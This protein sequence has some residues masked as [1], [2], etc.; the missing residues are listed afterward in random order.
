MSEVVPRR[1]LPSRRKRTYAFERP[2]FSKL[3]GSARPVRIAG[4]RPAMRQSPK[5]IAKP[6]PICVQGMMSGVICPPRMF[7]YREIS[8]PQ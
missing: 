1:V 7:T 3:S 4:Q 6:V 5:V 8:V 2:A